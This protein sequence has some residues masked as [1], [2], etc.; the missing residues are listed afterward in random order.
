MPEFST[1]GLTGR[2][3]SEIVDSLQAVVDVLE[4]ANGISIVLDV[5]VAI[6]LEANKYPEF[7]L[8]QD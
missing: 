3:N 1:I 2:N 4:D 7:P 6:L 8:E 5:N